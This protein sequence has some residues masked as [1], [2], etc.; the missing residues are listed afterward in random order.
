MAQPVPSWYNAPLWRT[1][2]VQIVDIK[3]PE[4]HPQAPCVDMLFPYQK[5]HGWS[6][7]QLG[8][9][10]IFFNGSTY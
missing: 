7:G 2:T 4:L 3:N 9:D 6:H 5:L 10:C 8:I 1:R